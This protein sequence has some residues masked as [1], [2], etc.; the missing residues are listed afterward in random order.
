MTSLTGK[1]DSLFA[2][3][4]K[5]DSPGGALAIIKDG[6]IIYKHGYGLANLDDNIPITPESVFYIASVSKQFTAACIVLLAQRGDLSLDDDIR[7]HIPKIP[8]YESPITIRHL[9][10]HTSGLRDYLDLGKF[11]DA[12]NLSLRLK[13][14][15]FSDTFCNATNPLLVRLKEMVWQTLFQTPSFP[16]CQ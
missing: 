7:T 14:S 10:H 12:C 3:W 5:P 13:K 16:P 9:I 15:T 8:A 11:R 4:D 6:S 1:V 2:E